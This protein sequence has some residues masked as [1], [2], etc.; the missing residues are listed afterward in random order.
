MVL[1]KRYI[2]FV[3]VSIVL[4]ALVVLE[5]NRLGIASGKPFF[6]YRAKTEAKKM[7]GL[8]KQG[9]ICQSCGLLFAYEQSQDIK[10]WM[11]GMRSPLDIIWLD[12]NKKII[13]IE[14]NV[15]PDSYPK[16]FSSARPAKYVLDFNAGFLSSRNMKEG[17]SVWFWN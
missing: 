13:H 14:Q 16:T 3:I 6:L 7:Q 2:I 9:Q 8:S 15:Q 1:M 11:K 17:Q 4:I 10:I 12:E 5:T